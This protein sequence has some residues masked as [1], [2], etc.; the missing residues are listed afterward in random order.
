[1]NPCVDVEL[2]HLRSFVAVAQERNFT[3]AA[4]RLH[5]AQPALSVHIRQLEERMGVQLVERTTRR[6]ALTPAGEALLERSR[7]LLDGVA[8]AVQLARDAA[9]GRTGRLRVGLL[10]TAALELIPVALRAFA[11]D[12]P[13]AQVSVHDVRFDDPSGGVRDGDADIAL[14]WTPVDERGLD[15]EPLFD[16]PRVAVLA[17]DHPL[18]ARKRLTVDDLLDQPWPGSQSTDRIAEAFWT[19]A[20]ERGGPPPTTVA[21]SGF[22]DLLVAIRAGLAVDTMPAAIA[23]ALP[24]GNLITRHVDGLRPTGV[25]LCRPEREPTR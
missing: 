12:V 10:A 16:E 19:L 1:M 8:D 15:V 4:E 22:E 23:H 21:V 18:A 17:A 2:K 20:H 7:A 9:L 11:A 6:V 14:I 3:R 5:L 13:G 25:A 24:F